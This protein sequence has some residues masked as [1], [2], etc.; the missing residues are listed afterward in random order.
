MIVACTVQ[1]ETFGVL[2][3]IE[4]DQMH[5]GMSR[6]SFM[7]IPRQFFLRRQH[8]IPRALQLCGYTCGDRVCLELNDDL[9]VKRII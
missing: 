4:N 6:E 2:A 8:F 3:L 1:S 5:S 7:G 9:S